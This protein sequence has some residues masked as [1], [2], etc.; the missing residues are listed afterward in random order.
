MGYDL[1]LLL[2]PCLVDEVSSLEGNIAILLHLGGFYYL[3]VKRRVVKKT[4]P[5]STILNKNPFL[6]EDEEASITR[7]ERE[8]GERK[9]GMADVVEDSEA[10]LKKEEETGDMESKILEAMK[11]RIPHFKEQS[12]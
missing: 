4:L 11:A 10:R 8:K 7:L 12:E 6:S 5:K 1:L 2:S 3:P 9:R